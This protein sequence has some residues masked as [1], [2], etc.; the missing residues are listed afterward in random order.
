[1]PKKT[2]RSI[3]T[4]PPLQLLLLRDKRD[5][6]MLPFEEA[7]EKAMKGGAQTSGYI[8]TGEDLGVEIRKFDIAPKLRGPLPTLMDGAC[9]TLV[10]ALV[11]PALTADIESRRF[12][13]KVW[14]YI[15][16][17][18]QH[19][20]LIFTDSEATAHDLLS[21]VPSLSS[22]LIVPVDQLAERALRAAFVSLRVL[23]V[24]RK[25][26]AEALH[27]RRGTKFLTLFIS[28]AKL[29]GLPLAQSL[30]HLITTL[31]WLEGFY[32]ARDLA[33]ISDWEAVLEDAAKSSL[34]VILRTEN[35]EQRPWCQKETLW[36]EEAAAPTVLVEARPGLAYPAGE[37]P[38]ERMPSVRIPDGNL[39]RILHAALREN[40]RYLLFQRRVQEMAASRTI[41][42]GIKLVVFSYPPSMSALLK[43]CQDI[44][45]AKAII[46]YPDPP[47]RRGLYEAATALVSAA[48]PKAKL[49][50]PTTLAASKP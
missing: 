50:T 49:V 31:P 41:P 42:A 24:A 34:L 20:L 40:L 10:I 35:Y 18:N 22:N 15:R 30:K 21:A 14:S 47:L 3:S 23:H 7:V 8:A 26:L 38:L 33:G 1:M 9:H 17:R 36:A 45:L 13:A 6:E 5:V 25:R 43:A 44:K 12:L 48:A 28:H 16:S 19:S 39:Y 4:K 29:D 2:S 46:I 27:G 32:D 37:L 11:G